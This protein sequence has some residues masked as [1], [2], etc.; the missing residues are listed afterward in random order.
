MQNRGAA[1]CLFSPPLRLLSNL[2]LGVVLL[3]CSIYPDVNVEDA[4]NNKATFK[5][6]ALDCAQAY[7]EADSGA[8]VKQRISCMNLKGWH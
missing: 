3:G 7:P 6:D 1:N 8:H 2:L 4:K 5:R